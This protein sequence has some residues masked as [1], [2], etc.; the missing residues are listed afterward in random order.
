M[1]PKQRWLV[2]RATAAIPARSRHQIVEVLL[3]GLILVNCLALATAAL[4]TPPGSSRGNVGSNSYD[5]ESTNED[6]STSLPSFYRSPHRLDGYY[7]P[8]D[9]Q[10]SHNFKISPKPCSFGRIEGTCMF[11]WECIKS[12]GQHVGMCVDSFMFGSCCAHNYTDN[13]VL[14]HTAFSY[15]RPTKPLSLRPR[16]PP[17]P[18]KPLISGMTTIERPHGAG[19]L[20]IRPSGPVH[21]GTLSRPHPKPTTPPDLQSAASQATSSS[22]EYR[23][24]PPDSIWHTSTHQQTLQQ[25]P[26]HHHWHMTTEP[27]FITK[28]R[29]TGWTKPG[30]VNLPA[31]M[32][33][34]KPPKPTKKPIVY[35]RPP[36]TPLLT[37]SSSTTMMLPGQTS[38]K[39]KP[40]PMPTRPQLSPGTSLATSSSS[41][42]TTTTTTKGTTT[43]KATTT[44]TTTTTRKPTKPY[45]RPTT[46]GTTTTST[47][48]T[49]TA[50]TASAAAGAPAVAST[51]TS[52]TAQQPTRQPIVQQPATAGIESNEI[53]DSSTH[54]A[55]TAMLGHVKT[56]SA[57]RSECGVPMLTRPETRIVG[58]K[59]AAF[60]RWPW[61]VSVRRT[62]FFGF[63][64]THRCGG[65]LINENWI[66]T[67]G[68]CVDD[69]LISQIRIRVGE[70]DFSHVQEQLPYIE[71]GV[72]K[73]VV[74]PK[75]NFFTYE[76][77]LALVKLEQPLEF[78]PH[79][80]PICLPETESL[81]IGMNATVTGWGRLSEGGTLP[82]VLQE[83]SVPIVSNDNCKSMFL[84]AGRQ[85]FIPDIFLCAGYETGGQ[86]SC[87]GDSGGPL[88]AKSQDGRFFLAGIISWGIGC[89]EAN[90]PGVCTR[91]S[92]FVPWILE[93]VR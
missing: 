50:G 75:Y 35:E 37:T 90:L 66:A 49:V 63:S 4:I 33:P 86:D 46:T 16:P 2:N 56:I 21:Q 42:A 65:A 27:S 39:P 6:D 26:Q 77:D 1:W 87:Q 23:M 76:Y 89:A 14:P 18:H 83:V 48:T 67:A 40:K 15:T 85:E 34:S 12:E 57:A 58:G 13:I 88:Q 64:S 53:T 9:L 84:R 24:A 45:Q 54:D 29:P 44:T 30:I 72:A 78:A 32:R 74:H 79:V 7:T 22:S 52:P 41:T 93:H 43:T 82:S 20:V 68:H 60:G 59:S 73:K 28:P 36:P 71:R 62:S 51:S 10:R 11:V 47:S 70:Y 55:G 69:L 19:T 3:V 17:Q 8:A 80:S 61:Q 5:Y 31:P 25:Q 81:L 92:K 38:P 91:I